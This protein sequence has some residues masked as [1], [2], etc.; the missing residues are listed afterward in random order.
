MF[1]LYKLLL[2]SPWQ[3]NVDNKIDYIITNNGRF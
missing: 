2:Y 3:E 1:I